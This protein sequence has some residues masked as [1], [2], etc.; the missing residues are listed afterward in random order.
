MTEECSWPILDVQ[1]A[2][3]EHR[4]DVHRCL[5]EHLDDGDVQV[6]SFGRDPRS[7]LATCSRCEVKYWFEEVAEEHI[8]GT[9]DDR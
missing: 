6:W 7:I 4:E 5:G 8:P 1:A 9:E 2:P 3:D